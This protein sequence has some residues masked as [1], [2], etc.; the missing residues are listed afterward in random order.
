[1]DCVLL[2]FAGGRPPEGT[3]LVVG[4][5]GTAYYFINFLLILPLI[6]K[7]ERPIPLPASIRR[8]VI[9]KQHAAEPATRL[10]TRTNN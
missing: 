6:G 10:L 7:F 5:W 4:R 8:A 9:S 3:W 2:T 1:V